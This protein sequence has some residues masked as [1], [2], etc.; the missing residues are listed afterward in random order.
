MKFLAWVYFL[1]MAIY[2][3]MFVWNNFDIP[4]ESPD[5]FDR[6]VYAALKMFI[7][8]FAGVH[9]WGWYKWKD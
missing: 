2:W 3:T 7:V 5:Q 4:I 6:V 1:P 9:L 8:G